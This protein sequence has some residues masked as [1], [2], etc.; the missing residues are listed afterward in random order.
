MAR[1]DT[2]TAAQSAALHRLVAKGVLSAQQDG[3]VR[4]AFA[5]AAATRRV[6]AGWLVEAAGYLGGTLLLAAAG[7]FVGAS[8][9]AMTG[10]CGAGCWPASRSPSWLSR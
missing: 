1:S 3:A 2:L 4:A 9:E 8:W 10:Q 5:D 7:L 6:P